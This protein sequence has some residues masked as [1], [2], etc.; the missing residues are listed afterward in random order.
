MKGKISQTEVVED[1]ESRPHNAVSFLVEREMEMQE[2][3]EQK[4]PKVLP[5][6]SGGRLRGRNTNE[7]GREEEGEVDKGSEE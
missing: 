5:G 4:L 2:W 7:K 6:C 1:V 3:N